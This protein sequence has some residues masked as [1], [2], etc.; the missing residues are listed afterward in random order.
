[1]DHSQKLSHLKILIVLCAKS[2]TLGLNVNTL[3]E[4]KLKLVNYTRFLVV[5]LLRKV[6]HESETKSFINSD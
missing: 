2:F 3:I 4:M 1:M 5:L 6:S